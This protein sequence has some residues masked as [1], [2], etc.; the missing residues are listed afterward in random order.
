M[1][2]IAYY[3]RNAQTLEMGGSNCWGVGGGKEEVKVEGCG[4]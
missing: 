3:I 2:L 1:I 4:C